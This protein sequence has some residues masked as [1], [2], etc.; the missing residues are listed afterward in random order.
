MLTLIGTPDRHQVFLDELRGDADVHIV[1]FT[2]PIARD[3]G[4]GHQTVYNAENL[5]AL[6]PTEARAMVDAGVAELVEVCPVFRPG[7][8]A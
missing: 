1:S 4:N 3:W 5:T 7:V 6:P 2:R 8:S